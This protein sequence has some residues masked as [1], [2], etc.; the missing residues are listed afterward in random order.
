VKLRIVILAALA[1]LF[2]RGVA[3][4]QSVRVEYCESP[5]MALTAPDG[6]VLGI[7]P[8]IVR[9]IG[10]RLGWDIVFVPGSMS[11]CPDRLA[12]GEVDIC[13][14]LPF[15]YGHD[16]AVAFT[17]NS[18]ISD[19]GAVYV[20]DQSVAG[21]R[22][23][24]GKRVGVRRGCVHVEAFKR[25]AGGLG[26]G[27]TL[28]EYDGDREVLDAVA[29][30]E[31]DAGIASRLFGLRYMRDFGVHET[32]VLFNPV[33][34]RFAGRRDNGVLLAALDTELGDLKADRESAYYEAMREW[35]SP[36]GGAGLGPGSAVF[37]AVAAVGAL[38]AVV[39]VWLGRRLFKAMFEADRRAKALS[40]ETEVRKRA[41]VALWESAERHRAMFTDNHLPLLFVD[42]SSMIIVEANPAAERFYGFPPGQLPGMD[43]RSLAADVRRDDSTTPVP[44]DVNHM[45]TRHRLARGDVRDVELFVSTV[46]LNHARHNLVTVLD[47]SER[48]AAERARRESEERLDLAVRGGDLAFWD[49][50]VA[51]DRL[52]FNERWAELLECGPDRLPQTF[53]D[54]YARF[55][56]DDAAMV[57]RELRRTMDGDIPVFVA[58]HRA[59][60]DTDTWRWLSARGRV[61]MRD[62][63]GAPLRMAGIAHDITERRRAE[64]RLASINTC[65]LGFT[66]DPDENISSLTGLIR[67][68]LGG[69]VGCYKRLDGGGGGCVSA[70][71]ATS[72]GLN[73]DC[74]DEAVFADM[75]AR[76]EPGVFAVPDLASSPY[77]GRAALP[78]GGPPSSF[79]GELVFM[80]G[81][82]VGVLY[83]L[84]RSGYEPTDNDRQ[85]M[86]IVAATIRVEEERK[87]SGQQLVRAKEVAESASRA[88]S[89]FLANMSHEIRTPLNGIFGMLQLVGGTS[90]DDEQ[91]DYVETALNSGRSL[92]RVIN[93]VLDFSKMEAGMLSIEQ[94]PL[95]FRRVVADVLE[96]F[97]VQAAEQQLLM[98]VEVDES[99][100]PLLVSDEARIRQI[101]FN[102]VGNAVKFTP[103][104]RVEVE[105]WAQRL[106]NDGSMRLFV[107]VNDTGIGIPAEMIDVV[108]N[109]FSQVDG[110]HT[111]KYGGT[112]LG[113]GIVRRLVG[114]MGGEVYVESD[115]E[116]TRIHLFIQARE[117]DESER[118]DAAPVSV[119]SS[120]R[121]LTVLLV[122]DEPV[123]RVSVLRQLEKLGHRV[124]TAEDGEQALDRLRSGD[125]DI[126]L[127]DIQMPG[128]DGLTATRLIRGD[129]SL[130]IR[131]RV[132]IVALTAHAM[133]GDREKFLEAG[134]DDYLAKPVDFTDMVRV[135]S[136]LA[137]RGERKS[138]A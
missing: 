7:A 130:G 8:D 123:N 101:L 77:S 39:T 100:P 38:L 49:W 121:P 36:E 9:A 32:P 105:A 63:D 83:V 62:T 14:A 12:G 41:Q 88:K 125:F 22:D 113:L 3:A 82:P 51:E 116:G 84:F 4:A 137:G 86:G 15:A 99:V 127:M 56:P 60:T 13:A 59:R 74:M 96:N 73:A 57:Q 119:P 93:D 110:S 79:V 46:Y 23:L 33:S 120:V 45:V 52:V 122:E 19:W 37:W 10:Q 124:V 117:A 111:R 55:H 134:M 34:L 68:L 98:A 43:L 30:G 54:W 58:E 44:A 31:V 115:G 20:L 29:R 136:G 1:C 24:D 69:Q 109:A 131:A 85:L 133:K 103:S 129:E 47:I 128:M 94:E 80:D 50:D 27:V 78:E 75:V 6:S 18:I 106:G 11:D 53:A 126:I 26:V 67:E 61:F 89:E 118:A 48:V 108:F 87:L 35:L 138:R 90:L 71:G 70:R 17:D 114:L 28:F 42:A 107:A 65:V 102:L 40:E 76:R 64:N 21:V 135:L 112:G 2:L 91:R 97:T 25:L 132:P 16:E 92:L 5:P 81:R 66:A 104:G 95:D 72:C